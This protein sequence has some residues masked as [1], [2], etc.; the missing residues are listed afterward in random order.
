[1]GE[2]GDLLELL[3]GARSRF[4]SAR[5]TLRYRHS[6]A[7]LQEARRHWVERSASLG[8]TVSLQYAGAGDEEPPD[9]YEERVRFWWEAP[10]RLREEVES[11]TPH[12]ARVHVVD[13]PVWW[14]YR[15]GHEALS[16]IDLPPEERLRHQAGGGDLLRPLL[17]P[18][19]F[20]SV[21]EI[22]EISALGE[23]LRFRA[24]PRD[25][26]LDLGMRHQMQL[27]WGAD[28]Y[29]LDVDRAT[30]VVRRVASLLGGREAALTELEELVLDEAFPAGTFTFTPPPGVMVEPPE[31]FRHRSYTLE[32]AAQEAPFTVFFVPDLPEGNWRMS[33]RFSPARERPPSPA[34]LFLHYQR[35]DGRGSIT[36]AQRPAGE[37]GFGWSG[38]GPPELDTV[39]RDGVEL[40]IARADTERGGRNAVEL[41]RDGTAVQLQSQEV[42]LE[43]LIR[44]ALSLERLSA[45][46]A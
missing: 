1:M 11:S 35:G 37:G 28:E 21:L 38:L 2:L 23:R 36:L 39:E 44:L 5:G 42:E 3:Y 19:G 16:N 29:E 33:V 6:N 31:P 43:T 25:D 12:Q 41:E 26:L 14:I 40:T 4:R 27:V 17:D 18:S 13:A 8:H 30:G 24:R 20:G 34:H 10:G 22:G 32:E 45:G 15:E 9:L 7:L 46:S